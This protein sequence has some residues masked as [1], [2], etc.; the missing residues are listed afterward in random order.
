[1]YP[2]APEIEPQFAVS[3]VVEIADALVAVGGAGFSRVV[4]AFEFAEAPDELFAR[5]RK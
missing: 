2:V 1:M 3:P 4:V 5:T